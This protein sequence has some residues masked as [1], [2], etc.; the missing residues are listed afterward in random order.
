MLKVTDST[1]SFIKSFEGCRLNAYQ[2]IAGV[3]TIGWGTTV[4]PTGVHVKKGD[5]IAQGYADYMIEKMANQYAQ[6]ASEYLKVSLNTEQNDAVVDFVYNAGVGAFAGST[7]LKRI[8]ADP[9]DPLITDAFMMWDK[10]HH[11]GQLVVSEDLFKRRQ[12]EA[13]LYF[14]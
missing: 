5:H 13:K 14:S 12:E 7:L 4:Y 10:Y 6:H 9:S 2:D 11:D 1:L 8:N 3:W